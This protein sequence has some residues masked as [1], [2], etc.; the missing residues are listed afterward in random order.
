MRFRV[1]IGLGVVLSCTAQVCG[2]A[3]IFD[4]A[5]NLSVTGPGSI[6]AVDET[7]ICDFCHT[8]HQA[9]TDAPLWNRRASQQNFVPYSSST[10]VAQP[11]QPTGNS[12]L[13]LS[14]HDG[15]IALGDVLNSSTSIVM[16]GG[17]VKMPPG[18][19]LTGTDLS[20]DHPVSFNY[21]ADLAA[22]RG[23]MKTPARLPKDIKLDDSGQM[24]CTTC[25]DAHDNRNGKFLVR[26]NVASQL[27]VECHQKN[28]WAQSSHRNSNAT[29]NGMQE[30]PWP[31]SDHSNV[32]DNA[33]GS[34]HQ[35]HAVTGGPRLLKHA[36]EEDNC[37]SCHN[38]NVAGKNVMQAFSKMS[39]H[40]VEDTTLLHDPAEPD[41]V[42]V[43]H[44]ECSDCHNVHDTEGP[45]G[46]APGQ[47]GPPAN[48][49]GIGIGG[50]PKGRA[51]RRYEICLR[52]HGDSPGQPPART[53]RQ[54]NQNNLRMKLQQNNPSFHPIAGPGRNANVPSLIAP[55]TEQSVMDCI[56]CHN[57]NSSVSA[58]G[59]GPEGPHG[60]DF[61]S[62][63]VRP[64]VTLDNTQ[65]SP[66]NYA[67]CYNC[68]D[69]DS[70]LNDESFPEHDKHIRGEDTPCN[71]C[72]DPH[73][74]S[75]TQGNSVNNS[76]LIN[77]DGS[78]VSP[79]G[80]GLL[81]FEDRGERAGSCDLSCHGEDHDDFSYNP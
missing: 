81:R 38:G 22:R 28:G 51:N 25:H 3:S 16:V 40:S 11:G 15:T 27:C 69:R 74:I 63:L 77:F 35:S 66:S 56:D 18:R 30:D 52:C 54:V 17:T 2:A 20:H 79:N 31:E 68:H 34:C 1:T 7:R 65:E 10:A 8:P 12:V 48:V 55:W 14:C 37:R 53:P 60:S 32:A 50:S 58:G 75:A 13:C 6:R 71:V 62:L 24:Q 57:S 39:S 43:R 80:Q 49:R 36:N 42:D 45:F 4:S 64:Y 72:H 9:S 47:R 26:P 59:N 76:H 78:V 23:E 67:L 33:C 61:Q 21:S 29:W 5:H 44:V 73:G 41:V 70:I 46:Q 19:N